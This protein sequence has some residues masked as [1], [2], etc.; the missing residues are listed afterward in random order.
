MF[1]R[2]SLGLHYADTNLQL[3]KLHIFLTYMI[4]VFCLKYIDDMKMSILSVCH[5]NEEHFS[6]PWCFTG[7]AF[8]VI[9]LSMHSCFCQ[10]RWEV[11]FWVLY[12]CINAV[13]KTY[14]LDLY[15]Y[16]KYF[17]LISLKERKSSCSMYCLIA[18]CQIWLVSACF[19]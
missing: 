1:V 15:S 7:A 16:R 10:C 17:I 12:F 9:W 14:L 11:G 2:L 13:L 19:I 4:R 18:L 8:C 6:F 3:Q 5:Y